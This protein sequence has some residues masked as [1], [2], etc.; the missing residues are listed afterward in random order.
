MYGGAQQIRSYV[1]V[2]TPETGA[3]DACQLAQARRSNHRHLK[4]HTTDGAAS[5][6]SLAAPID[7][8]PSLTRGR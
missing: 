4:H 5:A 6:L 8:P 3:S 1:N 7:A 2:H